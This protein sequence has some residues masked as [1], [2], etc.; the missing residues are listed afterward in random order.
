[1]AWRQVLMLVSDRA[2][3]VDGGLRLSLREGAPLDEVT[4]LAVAE[5][6]CCAFFSFALT[7]DDRGVALEVRAPADATE[8]LHALF[9]ADV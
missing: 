6:G 5:Q 2:P 3:T 7:I 4:R 9:G 1:E 8:I